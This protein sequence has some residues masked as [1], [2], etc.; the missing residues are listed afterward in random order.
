MQLKCRTVTTRKRK[1]EERGN[2]AQFQVRKATFNEARRAF[3]VAALFNEELTEFVATWF[4]PMEQLPSI[5]KNTPETWGIQPSKAKSSND[6]YTPYRC[7][8]SKELAHR[9]V[10]VCE[11]KTRSLLRI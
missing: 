9:I 2:V 4:I 11:A 7:L 10:D 1:S 6:R 8:T 5:G 3:F